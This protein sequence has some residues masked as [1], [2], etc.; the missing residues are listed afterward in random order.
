MNSSFSWQAVGSFAA[1][2]PLEALAMAVS[3]V[4][5]AERFECGADRRA[6][7]L[8]LRAFAEGKVAGVAVTGAQAGAAEMLFLDPADGAG[9]RSLLAA[10]GGRVRSV[11][12]ALPS[13]ADTTGLI[14][15][16]GKVTVAAGTASPVAYRLFRPA[17]R[18]E[19]DL[20][21][22]ADVPRFGESD[23]VLEQRSKWFQAREGRAE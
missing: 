20:N 4:A 6:L 7:L 18:G 10:L 9:A 22:P 17:D 8:P 16:P 13:E 12:V 1:G 3:D 2:G 5:P 23:D 21:R 15:E 19:L 14:P 11:R